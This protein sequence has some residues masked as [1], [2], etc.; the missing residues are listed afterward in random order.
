MSCLALLGLSGGEI[1]LILALVL[2][3]LGA[4]KLPEL[5][6][7]LGMGIDEFLK[8]TREVTKAVSDQ[9]EGEHPERERDGTE[10]SWLMWAA[11]M[12]GLICLVVVL[13]EFSK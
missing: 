1:M 5:A 11:I 10:T 7:G 12:L 6:K 2:V 9:I 4:R 8:A 3:L 13:Y